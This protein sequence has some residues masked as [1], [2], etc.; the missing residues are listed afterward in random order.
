M[1]HQPELFAELVETT[2]TRDLTIHFPDGSWATVRAKPPG[3]GWMLAVDGERW[4]RWTRRKPVWRP[5]R[6]RG[7]GGTHERDRA[8]QC[9]GVR[10]ARLSG[11]PAVLADRGR[12]PIDLL[13]PEKARLPVAG[14]TSAGGSPPTACSA[15]RPRSTSSR[16]G[17]ASKRRA[18]TTASA[19]TAICWCSTST[20][21]TTATNSLRRLEAEHGALPN[22]WRSITGSGGEHILFDAAGLSELKRGKA[23]AV[24]LG[25]GVDVP[26]YIV[27]AGSRHISGR[28]YAWNVDHHPRETELA[29]PPA[30]LVE[31]LRNDRAEAGNGAGHDPVEWA[32]SE[33]AQVHRISRS[34]RRPG[35]REIAARRFASIRPSPRPWFTIGTNATADRR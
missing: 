9:A 26:N 14:K 25:D 27:G 28:L 3:N 2:R 24:G 16:V 35:R 8:R 11:A 1:K 7:R 5:V 21:A 22:T 18:P 29:R 17:S 13:V 4:T 15:R 33:S 19:A 12:R 23:N 32:E 10:T 34:R 30:W 31:H 20:R 6:R